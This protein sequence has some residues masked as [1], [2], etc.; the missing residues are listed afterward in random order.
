M[1]Q[2]KLASSSNSGVPR[3]LIIMQ[4]Q[5]QLSE[6]N[7]QLITT[8]RPRL[9]LQYSGHWRPKQ[10]WMQ[11]NCSNNRHLLVEDPRAFQTA[12]TSLPSV[13]RPLCRFLQ[14]HGSRSWANLRLPTTT[15]NQKKK[16][17]EEKAM[18]R[19]QKQTYMAQLRIVGRRWAL[20]V[21]ASD[22][23]LVTES[24]VNVG[25]DCPSC[26]MDVTTTDHKLW[27][28]SHPSPSSSSSH[29]RWHS[30]I[31]SFYQGTLNWYLFIHPSLLW[32]SQCWS[33]IQIFWNFW[34]FWNFFHT[35]RLAMMVLGPF[36]KV[37][38]L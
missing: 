9:V 17:K 12:K 14:D 5:Q 25:L 13:I 34:N 11:W 20:D 18:A 1:Q 3:R 22:V 21:P 36:S 35:S 4:Q 32:I 19:K 26:R 7:N 29:L 16:K 30:F 33:G 15:R 28:F 6:L 38:I 8:M 10:L 23:P 2:N 24:R 37:F 31:H 27:Y